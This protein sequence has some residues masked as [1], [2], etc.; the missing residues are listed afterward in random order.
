MSCDVAI[1]REFSGERLFYRY[2]LFPSASDVDYYTPEEL[3]YLKHPYIDEVT[4][5]FRVLNVER[6]CTEQTIYDNCIYPQVLNNPQH[7]YSY[8]TSHFSRVS[9]KPINLPDEQ[10]ICI[11]SHLKDEFR[12]LENCKIENVF[13]IHSKIISLFNCLCNAKKANINQ[14][15]IKE[16]TFYLST[17]TTY[18]VKLR[19]IYLLFS[20][21]IKCF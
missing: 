18:E 6:S 12:Q 19:C 16:I 11:K 2:L 4:S 7:W 3:L 15:P 5:C 20:N 17:S 9:F 1:S 10:E 13:Q 8:I 14:K 21:R